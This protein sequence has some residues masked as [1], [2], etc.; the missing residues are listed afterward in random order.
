MCVII[1]KK[2]GIK[3]PKK[4]LLQNCFLSNPDG[5]GI[6]IQYGDKVYGWKGLMSFAAFKSKLS[7]IEKRFGNLD[8]LNVVMHFRIGTHGSNKPENTHPFPISECYDD[9]RELEWTAN[10]AVAHNGII[11]ITK[12][13]K[14]VKAE[15]VSDT[16]VFIKR[17][18]APVAKLV[19]VV[20]HRN[21]IE[22]FGI[23]SES[24]L[25]FLDNKGNMELYGDFND[26]DGVWYSNYSYFGYGRWYDPDDDYSHGYG[27]TGG[28]YHNTAYKNSG[29]TYKLG[30]QS[31]NV[32]P[33]TP[34]SS[35]KEYKNNYDYGYNGFHMEDYND[36]N[37]ELMERQAAAE[38]WNLCLVSDDDEMD[39]KYTDDDGNTVIMRL[40]SNYAYCPST[41]VLYKWNEESWEF[42]LF[43]LEK[44]Y[45]IVNIAD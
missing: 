2:K 23:A 38:D 5:A 13:H 1:A 37:F 26:Y 6:M 20:K 32:S 36:S 41:W 45:E 39:I 12:Y 29:S 30:T 44:E 35:G 33:W 25:A 16:M 27:Y 19:P 11:D 34:K 31:S 22:S 28:A 17:I 24:K 14:D 8:K 10:S 3:M 21:I 42:H 7:K 18:I 4:Y 43:K 40:D 9:L 15:D